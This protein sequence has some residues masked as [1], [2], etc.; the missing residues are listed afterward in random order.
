MKK[1][2]P[3][4]SLSAIWQR[5]D[6]I[7]C[8]SLVDRKDRQA[9]AKTQF[10]RVGLNERVDFFLARRHPVNCEQGIF[11]SH[12]SCLKMGLDAGAR[13]ILVFEDDVIFGALDPDRLSQGIDFFMGQTDPAIFFLGCLFSHSQPTQTP[14]VRRIRYRCLSHAYLVNAALARRIIETPWQGLAFDAA[15]RHCTRRHFAL[16]PSIA[17]QSN[18]PTDNTRHRVLDRIRRLFGG[19]RVIQLINEH[20][21]RYPIIVI[22]A[23]VLVIGA[24]ILWTFIR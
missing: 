6:R 16:Y 21:H 12:Q 20:Y 22:A 23:H 15:L 7:H 1:N 24:V 10:S 18:S 9:S 4:A 5:I 19:L 11:E 14:A 2:R 17:F 3:A 8:I 13:H